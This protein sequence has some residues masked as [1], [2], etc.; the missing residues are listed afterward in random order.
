MAHSE[1]RAGFA[2]A[3]L[4]RPAVRQFIQFCIVGA[5]STAI[6]FGIFSWLIYG[7]ELDR[8]LHNWLAGDPNLQE[9]FQHHRLYVQV[10]ALIGFII[11]VTN[12][13]I[14]NSRWTFSASGRQNRKRQYLQFVL[15]NIVGLLLNQMIVF[16]VMGLLTRGK[17][18]GQKGLE[19]L[20]A[21]ASA[22]CIVVFW[23]FWANKHWTFKKPGLVV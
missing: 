12:G 19:P 7:V 2:G 20:M 11:S 1:A 16:V 6:S 9:L 15:V 3:V 23:N 4:Q 21:A 18:P 22:T 17:A 14:W 10:A 5:T 13:F 8:L